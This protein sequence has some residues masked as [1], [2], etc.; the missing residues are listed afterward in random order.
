[1]F[2]ELGRSLD[3]FVRRVSDG[4]NATRIDPKT[5]TITVPYPDAEPVKL[6]LEMGIGELKVSAG[7]D[8]LVDGTATYN[9]QEW[10]PQ[11]TTDGGNVLVKQGGEKMFWPGIGGLKNDWVLALGTARPYDLTVSKGIVKAQ[12]ALGGLPLTSAVLEMG[13][14]ETKIDF[15]RINPQRASRIQLKCG[16]GEMRATGLLNTNAASVKVDGG[17]GQIFSRLHR[18]TRWHRIWTPIFRS[19]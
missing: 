9:I 19:A 3:S 6:R 11:I 15:D 16:T 12:L 17:T 5:D 14:G 10:T 1:M 4:V 18:R 7:A 8:K 13:T 2:E